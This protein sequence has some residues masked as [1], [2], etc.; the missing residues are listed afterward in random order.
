ME[1]SEI[2]IPKNKLKLFLKAFLDLDNLFNENYKE[3]KEKK[4][5]IKESGYLIVK[6]CFDDIIEKISYIQFSKYINDIHKFEQMI[7]K[8][9]ENIEYITFTPCEQII[10]KIS[11]ELEDK[12]KK[13]NEYIIINNS[14]WKLINNGKYKENEGKIIY[15][16]NNEYLKIFLCEGEMV[17]FKYNTNII[18]N[19][20]LLPGLKKFFNYSTIFDTNEN[21][22]S[23][24]GERIKKKKNIKN[25]DNYIKLLMSMYL[26][27][28][29]IN[30]KVSQ[31]LKK[32]KLFEFCY[33]LSKNYINKLKE[34]FNYEEFIEIIIKEKF[35][36]NIEE[37]NFNELINNK[38]IIDELKNTLIQAHFVEN[39]PSNVK[40]ELNNIKND[41][42]INKINKI[43]LKKEELY[44]FD[45]FEIISNSLYQIFEEENLLKK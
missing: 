18:R 14:V 29:Y 31:K 44:Y 5:I 17:Y 1:M 41:N 30:N 24:V 13:G 43:Y 32:F 20:N 16:I 45:V 38:E 9:Y 19:Q 21:N 22:Y 12:I 26:N 3:V 15:E 25:L 23:F 40:H 4:I 11:E 2:Q 36:E 42:E 35:F 33:I 34:I 39:L 6:K 8:K 10:F 27:D 7:N 37:K 28:E